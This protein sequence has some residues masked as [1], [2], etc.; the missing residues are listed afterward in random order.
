MKYR[1][2]IVLSASKDIRKKNHKNST[3]AQFTTYRLHILLWWEIGWDK[4]EGYT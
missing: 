3:F 4:G 2:K 1:L